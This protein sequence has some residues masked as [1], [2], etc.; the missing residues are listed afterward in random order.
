MTTLVDANVLLDIATE[1]AR[2]FDWSAQALATAAGAGHVAINP[3]IYAEVAAG[4][5]RVEDLNAALAD[6]QRLPLPYDAGF[7]AARCF[8][9]YR[10]AGGQRRSPL[11]DFSIGAH[12]AVEGLTLLTRDAARYR[13]YFP[14]LALIVP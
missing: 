7:L 6:F 14:R 2:W 10:R 4:F 13:T 12:A 5:S 1:D 8:V 3:L 11:P 9:R